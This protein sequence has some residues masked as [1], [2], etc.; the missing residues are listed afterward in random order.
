MNT[1]HHAQETPPTTPDSAAL[2]PEARDQRLYEA[3]VAFQDGRYAEASARPL[4]E[5]PRYFP[6]LLL[7]GMIA[8]KTGRATE[9]IEFLRSAI[10][11]DR[12]SAEARSE[13]ATL[14]RAEGQHEAAITEAKHA[15]RL[16]PEDAGCHNN[17]ALSY[18]AAGRASP[19]IM[20]LKRA[21]DLKSD[22]SMFHHNL[23]LALHEQ[24]RDFEAIAAFRQAIALDPDNS[25]PLARL[26][27]LLYRH[28]QREEAAQCYERAAARQRDPTLAAMHRAEALM[29]QGRAGEAEAVV[30]AVIEGDPASV[31]AHQVLGVLLQRL[32][33]FDDA[34]GAFM[35]ALELEP[36]RASIW[37]NL[38]LGKRF[39]PED[40]T[41]VQRMQ[42]LVDDPGIVG[43][44]RVVLHFALGK[45]HDDRG[46][47]ELAMRHFDRAH[48]AESALMRY[49]CRDFDRQA[50]KAQ[51]DQSIAEFTAALLARPPAGAAESELPILIVGM[52]RSGT[53]LVEQILSSHP[54]V[55][56]AGELTWWTDRIRLAP[57]VARG[58]LDAAQ[59]GALAQGY[60][61][62]LRGYGPE[63]VRVTDKMPANFAVLGLIHL[64]LPRA[65]IV[66]CRRH[67]VDT[68]LSVWSTPFGNPLDFIHDRGD[69]VFWYEQ[70]ARLMAHWR[71]VL[72]PG[73]LLEIDYET[74]VAE[75]ER[76]TREMVAFCGLD[77]HDACLAPE[78]NEHIILTPSLWQ[79][80]QPVYRTSAGRWRRYEPWL[81]A[82]RRLLPE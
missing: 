41:L 67:P 32:A 28:G 6:A 66:H 37:S 71:Q 78:R 20:H 48:E 7:M 77:W 14:L 40:D 80:R 43:K 75:P 4:A 64:V 74:L 11:L 79:A 60:L 63:A 13:L 10:A 76:V 81:G 72:P 36:R 25:E 54:Q 18:L 5:I 22:A 3:V 24:A 68:C 30:R 21:I 26:G 27:W 59:L 44:D 16:A 17:L 38:V 73:R 51:F 52:P 69:L 65:R 50:H 31:L 2:T 42:A 35:Q 61:A 23:G 53:T 62:L 34:T 29:Q 82:F 49:S 57:A 47:H 56:A 12:R 55:G 46:E 15:V 45:A 9:G 19:A 33:R 70:Y 58:R 1:N 8:A 39:G